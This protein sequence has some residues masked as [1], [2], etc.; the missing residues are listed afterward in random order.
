MSKDFGEFLSEWNNIFSSDEQINC[1]ECQKQGI[2]FAVDA[3]EFEDHLMAHYQ[4]KFYHQNVNKKMK[5][6]IDIPWHEDYLP[7]H[8]DSLMKMIRE[9]EKIEEDRENREREVM[10]RGEQ[11]IRWRKR[12]ERNEPIFNTDT[13]SDFSPVRKKTKDDRV[14]EKRLVKKRQS[15]PILNR[16]RSK[17][18]T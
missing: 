3:S 6:N 4:V 14:K 1:Q 5:Q 9:H 11:K 17:L 8:K 12:L 7:V 18:I 16:R 15:N 10:A 13:E 2:M